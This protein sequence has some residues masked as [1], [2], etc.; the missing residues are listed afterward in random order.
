MPR[1]FAFLAKGRDSVYAAQLVCHPDRSEA[2][3][4]AVESLHLLPT[5]PSSR[6]P[7]RHPARFLANGQYLQLIAPQNTNAA[8]LSSA[9]RRFS[10]SR[11]FS[12]LPRTRCRQPPSGTGAD[13]PAYRGCALRNADALPCCVRSCPR[14]RSPGPCA[15]TVHPPTAKPERCPY[16]VV[17]PL[18]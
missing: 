5:P 7:I 4:S 9:R 14:S 16:R 18:P 8:G 10:L 13:S 1:P 17:M 3:P 15:P 6:S 11:I 12:S 2:K